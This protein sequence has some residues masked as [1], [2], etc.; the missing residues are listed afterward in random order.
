MSAKTLTINGKP[1]SAREDETI[2]EA[3]RDAGI[4]MPTLCHLDGLTDIGACRLCLDASLSVS[5]A[6][7]GTSDR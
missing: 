6:A 1:I 3:A 5:C 7:H 2:L 4:V